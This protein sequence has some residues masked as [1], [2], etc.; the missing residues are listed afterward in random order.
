MSDLVG[1]PNCWFSYAK[2]H[3][4]TSVINSD[5]PAT[6]MCCVI[7]CVQLQYDLII[8]DIIRSID[9][10]GSRGRC[11]LDSS[12]DLVSPSLLEVL[13]EPA[14]ED[15]PGTYNNP[16]KHLVFLP[17]YQYSWLSNPMLY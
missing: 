11:F 2:A 7:S 1:N 6:Y 5:C 12:E 8:S 4:H 3:I 10:F 14:S 9:D 16:V 17:F 15:S 13:D